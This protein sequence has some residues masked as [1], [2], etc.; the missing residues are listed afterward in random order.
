[1]QPPDIILDK[2]IDNCSPQQYIFKTTADAIDCVKKN[3]NIED[4]CQKVS[5]SFEK[6]EAKDHFFSL[7]STMEGVNVVAKTLGECKQHSESSFDV[8][9]DASLGKNTRCAF[10]Q[11]LNLPPII[12]MTKAVEF[13]EGE[14]FASADEAVKCVRKHATAVDAANG[15]REVVIDVTSEQVSGCEYTVTVSVIILS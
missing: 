8:V 3:S 12:D 5:E 2:V 10:D 11:G 6:T 4:D 13:C 14:I 9:V 1:M 15:C 7:C